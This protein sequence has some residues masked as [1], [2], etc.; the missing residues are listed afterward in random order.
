M[1]QTPTPNDAQPMSDAHV[2]ALLETIETW[3]ENFT[4][5]EWDADKAWQYVGHL[6]RLRKREAEA[7]ES[8]LAQANA[9]IAVM[10]EAGRGLQN[11][12]MLEWKNPLAKGRTYRTVAAAGNLRMVLSDLP[13]AATALLREREELRE[14]LKP[15]ADMT[16]SRWT[17][18]YED[19]LPIAI[20]RDF[21]ADTPP[22]LTVGD[23]R[24]ARAALREAT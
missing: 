18:E 9:K 17:D 22:Y 7:A 14:A 12:L 19:S 5:N 4:G 11:A 24:K 8:A 1:S 6:L 10:S 15:F 3:H 21:I 13:A 2:A 23:L 16:K 20:I